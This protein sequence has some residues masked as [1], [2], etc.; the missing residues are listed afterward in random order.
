MAHYKREIRIKR[1]GLRTIQPRPV[2]VE[3]EDLT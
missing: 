2:V 3:G 1:E